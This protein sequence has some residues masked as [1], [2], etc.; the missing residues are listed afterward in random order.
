MIKDVNKTEVVG[1]YLCNIL[2]INTPFKSVGIDL[3][4]ILE[5]L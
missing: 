4:S 2:S 5:Y 1:R 3:E